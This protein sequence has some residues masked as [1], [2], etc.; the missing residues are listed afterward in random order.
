MNDQFNN[1]ARDLA[2]S[3]NK[4]QDFCRNIVDHRDFVDFVR[5]N[6]RGARQVLNAAFRT[7]SEQE[8]WNAAMAF[9]QTEGAL[10]M[11][12]SHHPEYMIDPLAT[13]MKGMTQ[14]DNDIFNMFLWQ[15]RAGKA[16]D[17][18]YPSAKIHLLTT[19][20]Q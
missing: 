5:Q 13:A 15:T 18:N 16:L 4:P 20:T 8:L 19:L 10:V 3:N 1:A 14:E 17:T 6:L 11:A 7:M 9:I 2:T 12:N